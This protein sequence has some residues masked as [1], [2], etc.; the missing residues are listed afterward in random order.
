M[1]KR[2]PP[3]RWEL[4]E[5]IDPAKSQCFQ[6]PVPDDK[7]HVAA[8]MG[9]IKSLT[10]QKNWAR[11]SAHTARDV[12]AVWLEIF[13]NLERCISAAPGVGF[14]GAGGDDELMLRQN[15]DNPCELQNSVDGVTWC[16][17]ADLSLCI[18]PA[19]PGG[20]SPQPTP[21]GGMQCYNGKMSANGQWLLP[22]AV[23]TGDTINLSD[24]NGAGFAGGS[25]W[26]CGDGS[27]F[28]AGFCI[29]GTQG[30]L[31]S[32]PVPL[33][34]TMAFIVNIGGTFY[35]IA[36][37]TN[38]TVPG[39]ISNAP[40]S[41]QVNDDTLADNYGDYTFKVCVTN[42]QAEPWAHTLLFAASPQRFSIAPYNP[43][44]DPGTNYVLGDGWESGQTKSNDGS[45]T[46]RYT[47]DN[48]VYDFA[49]N[50]TLTRITAT[51]DMTVGTNAGGSTLG[52]A[53]QTRVSGVDTTR[54]FNAASNGS[55]QVVSWT[56]S[57][58]CDGIR[59]AGLISD[60]GG[61]GTGTGSMTWLQVI[62]EGEGFDPWA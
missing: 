26:Y 9:A 39:G 17:W 32:N 31:G 20:G 61:G 5:V 58:V 33:A 43:G 57:V 18:S 19:Q 59:L 3:A 45:P 29:D 40:V 23:S 49:E 6:I 34:P 12:A 42:N 50:T 55:G 24:V 16:T 52:A 11:D 22:T 30:Y 37:E 56:G 62:V 35:A 60:A 13:N 8:F 44:I 41:F 21:G 53:A 38:F 36:Q 15:P 1:S 47:V 51:Y 46:A 4:P 7:Y 48:I 25:N 10:W 14:A 54:A 28:V 27:I 2:F